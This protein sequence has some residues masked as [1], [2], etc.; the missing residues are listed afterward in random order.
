MSVMVLLLW[1]YI[2]KFITSCLNG[3]ITVGYRFAIIANRYFPL[4]K[5]LCELIKQWSV[6]EKFNNHI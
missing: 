2:S 1:A 4:S 5:A 3:R 6:Y